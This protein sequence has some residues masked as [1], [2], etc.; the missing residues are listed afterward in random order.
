M[1]E[2]NIEKY[3]VF[4]FEKFRIEIYYGYFA[5]CVLSLNYR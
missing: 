3:V 2:I 5:I 1:N 4:I